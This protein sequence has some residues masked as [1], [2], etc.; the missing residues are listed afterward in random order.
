MIGIKLQHALNFA[1][2][3]DGTMRASTGKK[4]FGF[5]P[6]LRGCLVV[7][8]YRG[9]MV[10]F[11]NLEYGQIEAIEGRASSSWGIGAL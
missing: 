5:G 1:D 8:V 6:V 7:Y 2:G 9:E 11:S 4:P 3:S 10:H